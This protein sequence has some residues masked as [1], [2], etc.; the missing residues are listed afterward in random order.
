[1]TVILRKPDLSR[2]SNADH[3][4]FHKAA[5][6]VG[7]KYDAA[8][9]S[10][11]NLSAY[12]SALEQEVNVFKWIR[13]SAFT[14]KKAEIDHSRDEIYMGMLGAVRINLKHF[15]PHVRDAARHVYSLLENY[16]NLPNAGCDAETDFIDS[17]IAQLHGSDYHEAAQ[18]L[19]IEMWISELTRLNNLF[20]KQVEDAPQRKIN[21]P[22]ISPKI[23]RRV[24]DEALQRIITRITAQINLYGA[25]FYFPFI[26]EFN[27][28]TNRYNMLQHERYD[29]LHA[30]IDLAQAEIETIAPQAFTGK[31]VFVIPSISLRA[32]GEKKADDLVFSKDFTLAYVNHLHPGTATLIIKGIGKYKG[33]RITTFTIQKTS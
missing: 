5:L 17:L 20:K 28:L 27:L 4:A 19:A 24:T 22:D 25:S 30:K 33:E 32:T 2:Y 13:K 31:P 26:E 15:A 21:H 23:A 16:G 10:K 8:V 3:L 12:V 18:L 1:M 14:D 9:G 29:R 6:Q 7:L 11:D